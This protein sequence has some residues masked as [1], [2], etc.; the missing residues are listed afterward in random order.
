M[1]IINLGCNNKAFVRCDGDVKVLL[2]CGTVVAVIDDSG[3]HRVWD[4]YSQTT[5]RHVNAFREYYGLSSMTKSQWDKLPI[6]DF[7]EV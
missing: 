3:F 5:M 7:K 2:S 1:A 4:D 6:Y